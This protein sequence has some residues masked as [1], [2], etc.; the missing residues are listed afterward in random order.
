V[1]NAKILMEVDRAHPDLDGFYG[2]AE[3]SAL[4][5][6]RSTFHLAG[7]HDQKSHGNRGGRAGVSG[8][9]VIDETVADRDWAERE[10]NPRLSGEGDCYTAALNAMEP[11]DR[12]RLVHGVVSGQGELT[13]VRFDHAWVERHD[14]IPAEA[15]ERLPA[16]AAAMLNEVAWTVI[17]KSN[18]NDI[19]MPRPLYYAIGQVNTP[20]RYTYE[21]MARK[22]VE[23]GNA[24]PWDDPR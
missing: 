14:P 23:T 5:T 6:R 8:A 19:E 2:Q 13:G 3:E 4:S 1:T 11:D 21:E 18:G 15:A 24:G 22:M 16:E 12:Y 17:D 10:G 9:T 20:Q 7:Q